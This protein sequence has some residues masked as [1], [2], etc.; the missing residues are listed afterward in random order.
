MQCWHFLVFNPLIFFSGC[1]RDK[2]FVTTPC[3]RNKDRHQSRGLLVRLCNQ[4]LFVL[5]ICLPTLFYKH[6]IAGSIDEESL[7][8]KLADDS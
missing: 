5:P 2:R 4:A 3:T 6:L 1:Y 7:S 8:D